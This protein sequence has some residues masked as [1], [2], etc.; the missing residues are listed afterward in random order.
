MEPE[1]S[2]RSG[3]SEAWPSERR[4]KR[5]SE[6]RAQDE[7]GG[8]LPSKGRKRKGD[9]RRARPQKAQ[10]RQSHRVPNEQQ[11]RFGSDEGSDN[12]D[13]KRA[14]DQRRTEKEN[15]STQT[16]GTLPQDGGR[17]STEESRVQSQEDVAMATSDRTSQ[18]E[19]LGE[20]M[21]GNGNDCTKEHTTMCRENR[22]QTGRSSSEMDQDPTAS[23][24]LTTEVR[25]GGVK[26]GL[27]Q[28]EKPEEPVCGERNE[29]GD[30]VDNE[31]RGDPAEGREL[32][33]HQEEASKDQR[34]SEVGMSDRMGENEGAN[35]VELLQQGAEESGGRA[36]SQGSAAM[37]ED[38]GQGCNGERDDSLGE[39]GEAAAKNARRPRLRVVKEPNEQ[40]GRGAAKQVG[41][42]R[43]VGGTSHKAARKSQRQ[44]NQR[45]VQEKETEQLKKRPST[46]TRKRQAKDTSWNFRKTRSQRQQRVPK[47]RD[48]M[49]PAGSPGQLTNPSA[50][51]ET[52]KLSD[53]AKLPSCG[54]GRITSPTEKS[55]GTSSPRTRSREFSPQAEH[56]SSSSHHSLPD[57][58]TRAGQA[59]GSEPVEATCSS[60]KRPARENCRKRNV[61]TVGKRGKENEPKKR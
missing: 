38:G 39:D 61:L 33:I 60:V 34:G 42:E 41:T 25:E 5:T 15:T 3:R 22:T 6:S 50:G 31:V 55:R 17:L 49:E 1:P 52:G 13:G 53:K 47:G 20:D 30:R 2:P 44:I 14:Q 24:S 21:P 19:A 4:G 40:D 59:S 7:Q 57:S 16:F 10:S 26:E 29:A 11:S 35:G 23:G 48:D 37:A 12:T 36:K 43:C 56:R 46:N 54:E 58:A 9:R 27:T 45:S 28:E 18:V 8:S 32:T 51:P